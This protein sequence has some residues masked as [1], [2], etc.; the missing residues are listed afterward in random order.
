MFYLGRSHACSCVS[1][2]V[3]GEREERETKREGE[4]D[5]LLEA[6][7]LAREAPV[8]IS[9]HAKKLWLARKVARVFMVKCCRLP[10]MQVDTG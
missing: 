4:R 3:L 5:W 8:I 9:K 1:V 10:I 7:G 6:R 2:C